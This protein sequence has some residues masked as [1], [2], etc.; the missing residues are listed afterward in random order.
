MVGI[1]NLATIRDLTPAAARSMFIRIT[2]IKDAEK[3][4]D[5][6]RKNKFTIF[7]DVAKEF[8]KSNCEN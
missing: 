6:M 5:F 4:V 3:L 7:N 8:L 1:H 2:K